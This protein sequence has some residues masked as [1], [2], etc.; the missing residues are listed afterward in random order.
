MIFSNELIDS[1]ELQCEINTFYFLII[2]QSNNNLLYTGTYKIIFIAVLNFG[3][4]QNYCQLLRS[5]DVEHTL[6]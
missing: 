6:G 2:P 3:G 1:S 4:K 5:T